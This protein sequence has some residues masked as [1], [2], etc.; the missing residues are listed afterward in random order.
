MFQFKSV[1]IFWI[2]TAVEKNCKSDLIGQGY[3]CA[4]SPHFIYYLGNATLA[5]GR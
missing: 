3:L 1:A 4:T 5:M 2:T